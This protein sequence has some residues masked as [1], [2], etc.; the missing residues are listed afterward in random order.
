MSLCTLAL[1][2]HVS[3]AIGAFISLGIWQLSLAA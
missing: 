1:F 3:D 2:L